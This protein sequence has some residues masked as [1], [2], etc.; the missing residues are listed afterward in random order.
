MEAL[1]PTH[2]RKRTTMMNK[3]LAAGFALGLALTLTGCA[4]DL[5]GPYAGPDGWRRLID[6]AA[7]ERFQPRAQRGWTMR[8]TILG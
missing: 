1:T 8:T 3:K 5:H 4:N 7:W 6:P 2:E